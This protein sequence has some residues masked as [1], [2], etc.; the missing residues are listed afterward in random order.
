M[1]LDGEA[2]RAGL[3]LLS[4]ERP[5]YGHSPFNPRH[6]VAGWAGWAR[7]VLE[8]ADHLQVWLVIQDVFHVVP[9]SAYTRCK[10]TH[11]LSTTP[12]QLPAARYRLTGSSPDLA[13]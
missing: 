2:Q 12:K 11:G 10:G 9:C 7:V 6:T 3:R 4:L 8:L 1:V 5:G 13:N